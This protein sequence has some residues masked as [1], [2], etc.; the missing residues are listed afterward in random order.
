[1]TRD[2]KLRLILAAIAA[3]VGYMAYE[4]GWY[5]ALFGLLVLVRARV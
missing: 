4:S 5:A 1:M 2:D 3:G